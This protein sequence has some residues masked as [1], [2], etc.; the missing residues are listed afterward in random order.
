MSPFDGRADMIF[1]YFC[2]LK[3]AMYYFCEISAKIVY[4][5]EIRCF[6]SI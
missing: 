1:S 2:L 6:I 3:V 5:I 4:L